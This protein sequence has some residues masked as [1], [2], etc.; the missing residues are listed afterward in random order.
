LIHIQV[1]TFL[2]VT[3][4]ETSSEIIGLGECLLTI[5]DVANV[6]FC[7]SSVNVHC[8][9]KGASHISHHLYLL[10]TEFW[11]VPSRRDDLEAAALMF[12][13]LL[14]PRG[15]SWTRNGVPKTAAAHNIL[16]MEKRKATPDDLCRGLPAEFEEFL[17][18]TRRLKF[19]ENPDYALWVDRFRDLA[20][21]L[22]FMDVEHFVWP[23]APTVS[24]LDPFGLLYNCP[25]FASSRSNRR[26]PSILQIVCEYWHYHTMKWRASLTAL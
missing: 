7:P 17:S 5:R 23:P 11:S 22:G 8:R 14:T 6:Y 4:S 1:V 18:Y 16:K 2:T 26:N 25:Y 20:M 19:K 3:S 15:L 9:G 21:E 10:V 12:I 24:I 13:H